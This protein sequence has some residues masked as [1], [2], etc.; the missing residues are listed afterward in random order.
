MRHHAVLQCTTKIFFEFLLFIYLFFEQ[1]YRYDKFSSY[2]SIFILLNF[3]K[4]VTILRRD[5]PTINK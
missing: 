1:P 4:P 5:L 3:K 2:V